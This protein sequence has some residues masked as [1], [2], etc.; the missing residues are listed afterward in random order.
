VNHPA[1]AQHRSARRWLVFIA[2][3]LLVF[4]GRVAMRSFDARAVLSDGAKAYATCKA[5]WRS[6]H[7]AS[8]SE[9]FTLWVMSGGTGKLRDEGVATL[10][11]RCRTKAR[12]RLAFSTMLVAAG[13]F[14]AWLALART[15]APRPAPEPPAA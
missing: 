1:W 13:A 9:R 10:G 8:P 2:V 7:V 11:A 14:S 5:P 12:R 15:R 3:L 4:A 6:A